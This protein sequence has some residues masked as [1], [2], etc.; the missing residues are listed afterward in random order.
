MPEFPGGPDALYK[1]IS[2][3]TNYPSE[4]IKKQ[5]QGKVIITFVIEKDGSITNIEQYG[6]PL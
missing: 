6:T 1:F 2:Q 5:I 3:N 4:A